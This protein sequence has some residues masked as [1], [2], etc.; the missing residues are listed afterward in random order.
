MAQ[1]GPLISD[2]TA[3]TLSAQRTPALTRARPRSQPS[4]LNSTAQITRGK[5]AV[6]L[7]SDNVTAALTRSPPAT[8]AVATRANAQNGTAIPMRT[9][10]YHSHRRHRT[11]TAASRREAAVPFSA[12]TAT[13]RKLSSS[14]I[15]RV[16]QLLRTT[17]DVTK[18]RREAE[19]V[20]E[21]PAA[22]TRNRRRR[23][24]RGDDDLGHGSETGSSQRLR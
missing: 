5:A 6:P 10:G 2:P 21:A 1:R 3:P 16:P 4:H 14:P 7:S 24:R 22:K 19:M 9:H 17:R 15:K 18:A 20:G 8:P 13:A 11:T 23:R 12:S